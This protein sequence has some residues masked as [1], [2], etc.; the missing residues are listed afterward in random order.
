MWPLVYISVEIFALTLQIEH[1]VVMIKHLWKCNHLSKTATDFSYSPKFPFDY[2]FLYS[3]QVYQTSVKIENLYDKRFYTP[4]NISSIAAYII[5]T[6]IFRLLGRIPH[7][8]NVDIRVD[9]VR[10]EKRAL[11]DERDVDE[12]WVEYFS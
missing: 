6:S 3:P 12:N 10:V 1:V 11:I 2:F 7:D 9:A 4:G 5:A 8:I